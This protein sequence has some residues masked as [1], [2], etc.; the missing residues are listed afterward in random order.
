MQRTVTSADKTGRLRPIYRW[1]RILFIL[2]LAAWVCGCEPWPNYDDDDDSDDKKWTLI[3]VYYYTYDGDSHRET[4]EWDDNNANARRD[5]G[6]VTWKYSYDTDGRRSGYL[7]YD[8][9]D[10]ANH[11]GIGTYF[12]DSNDCNDR[13]EEETPQGTNLQ[14]WIYYVNADCL[15]TGYLYQGND[16]E[17]TG[18]YVRNDDG[19]VVRLRLSTGEYWLYTLDGSGVRSRYDFYDGGD[20]LYRYGIYYYDTDGRLEELR[21]YEKR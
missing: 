19:V 16:T 18:T 9:A 4:E 1:H 2:L 10:L 11:D 5:S 13:L 21:N 14:V 17:E 6:D 8:G 3:S 12:Y 15:R 7:R 20:N